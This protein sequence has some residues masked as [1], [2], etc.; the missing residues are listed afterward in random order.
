MAG[1]LVVEEDLYM[2]ICDDTC[3]KK[4]EVMRGNLD[5]WWVLSGLVKEGCL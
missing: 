2:Y 5:V 4:M 3:K 1:W